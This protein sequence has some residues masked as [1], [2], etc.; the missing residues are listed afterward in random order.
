M[1]SNNQE[2]KDGQPA[3]RKSRKTITRRLE[4]G[5]NVAMTPQDDR[6]IRMC[7]DY[8]TGFVKR[9]NL[10]QLIEKKKLELSAAA[11]A[12]PYMNTTLI[13]KKDEKGNKYLDDDNEEGE[14]SVGISASDPINDGTGTAPNEEDLKVQ[15][16]R[17]LKEE[18]VVL[19]DNLEAHVAAD[20]KITVK[21]LDTVLKKKYGVTM[22]K[23]DLEVRGL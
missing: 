17:R 23:K 14:T 18:L 20:H 4:M 8:I 6:M 22:S 10:L 13:D 5:Q 3:P 21:D 7:F 19:E 2:E 9:S 15:A 12:S 16:Y 1:L 11:A